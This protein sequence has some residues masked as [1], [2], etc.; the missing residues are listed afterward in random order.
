MAQTRPSYTFSEFYFMAKGI[1]AR[2]HWVRNEM[3]DERVNLRVN[4]DP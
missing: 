4:F 2:R 3:E 1:G